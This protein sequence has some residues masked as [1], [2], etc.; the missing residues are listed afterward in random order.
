MHAPRWI[1]M[2]LPLVVLSACAGRLDKTV[3]N[4]ASLEFSCPS[5]SLSVKQTEARSFSSG[6]FNAS[7]CERTNEYLASCSLLMCTSEPTSAI[8]AREAAKARREDPANAWMLPA[9]PPPGGSTGPSSGPSQQ[10]ASAPAGRAFVTTRL[11][12][13]CPQK[14]LLFHGRDPRSS[15]RSDSIGANTTMNVS[16]SEG[17]A[18]W[19][20]DE[21]RNGVSSFTYSAG[22][23]ELFISKS[24]TG[25]T[26]RR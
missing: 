10:P 21:R 19:I 5:E 13:L 14:V 26:T 18:I 6:V 25:F 7:G 12:N 24:C 8:A 22:V 1:W 15:G 3:R 11:T 2:C 20:V 16:G 4:R 23:R 17:D 9:E